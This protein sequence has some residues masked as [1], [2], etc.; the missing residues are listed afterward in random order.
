MYERELSLPL[1]DMEETYIAFKVICEKNK[2]KYTNVD[3]SRIDDKY[4]RAKEKL[5]KMLPFEMK[6]DELDP[7]SHQDRASTYQQYIDGCKGFLNE[8]MIQ[9][10]Y[11]R[12][13]T[14][15]CL[16]GEQIGTVIFI[17]IDNSQF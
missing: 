5:Q 14:D 3:W 10:L 9:A 17:S 1:Y 15:C 11:E 7:R 2:D 8:Q 13:V 16:N 4:N 12:M 6:L